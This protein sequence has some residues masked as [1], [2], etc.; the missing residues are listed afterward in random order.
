VTDTKDQAA[1]GSLA[2]GLSAVAVRMEPRDAAPV[3]A[4]AATP[5]ARAMK[6]T[7]DRNELLWLAG[8]LSAVAPGVEAQDAAQVGSILAQAMKDTKE[9]MDLGPLAGSLSAVAARM[10]SKDAALVASTLLQSIMDTKDRNELSWRVQSLSALLSP[11]PPAELPSR[12][13]TAASAVA[14]PAGT[15]HPLTALALVIPTTEPSPCRLSTQQ[16]VDLLKMPT[17]VDEGRRILLDQ[18]GNRYHRTFS[19]PWEFVRFA[20]EQHL[21]LDFT[22]PPQRP[23]LATRSR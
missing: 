18:L 1:L 13:A 11:V 9:G 23:E 15:A 5:L 6:G 2:R 22:T 17:C 21:D 8:G 3:I 16:L 19:D 10:E 12:S 20:R 14:F 4:Q 7:R